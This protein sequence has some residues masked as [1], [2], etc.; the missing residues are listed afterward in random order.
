MEIHTDGPPGLSSR[1]NPESVALVLASC[2]RYA[3]AWDPWFQGLSKFW[4]S[5]PY[6]IYHVS[7]TLCW[8]EPFVRPLLTGVDH[9]WSDN[10]IA[11]VSRL[12]EEYVFLVIDDL[13]FTAAVATDR[14]HALI[15][16]LHALNGD[17]LRLNGIP[18]CDG[19][20]T[21]GLGIIK[22]GAVYRTATVMSVWKRTTLLDLL[23]SGEN[24]W[25]FEIAGSRRSDVYPAFYGTGRAEFKYVNAIVKGKWSRTAL[26]RLTAC[27]IEVR[28]ESRPIMSHR[29]ELAY[30]FGLARNRCLYLLPGNLRRA[31]RE[32][33]GPSYQVRAGMRLPE[34]ASAPH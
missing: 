22:P 23:R 34:E 15:S 3:D 9:S 24:A 33:F 19:P 21:S 10:L 29:E 30:S 12:S 25:E 31:V 6:P 4:P 27:G 8:S 28:S 17:Y 20:Y 11:A 13:I 32:R 2:D 26:N 14:V 1:L 5:C 16:Q 7:N 18:P